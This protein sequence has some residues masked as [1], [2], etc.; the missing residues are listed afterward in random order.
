MTAKIFNK[1]NLLLTILII[2][3]SNCGLALA[4]DIVPDPNQPGATLNNFYTNNGISFY[5]G[6]VTACNATSTSSV[7]ES[8]DSQETIWNNLIAKNL[9][10][11]QVAG[12]MGNMQS[13]SGFDPLIIQ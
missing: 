3:F 2:S 12:I 10:P 1:P 8:S 9:Q 13:E 7:A 6:G 11:F 4:D 5:D